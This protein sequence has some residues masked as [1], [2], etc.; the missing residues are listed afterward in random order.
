MNCQSKNLTERK[1]RYT[2]K[3]PGGGYRQK[4]HRTGW[5]FVERSMAK[6]I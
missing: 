1:E 2:K 3:V 4:N 6:D 5:K